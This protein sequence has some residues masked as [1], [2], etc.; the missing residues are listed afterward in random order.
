MAAMLDAPWA[1]AIFAPPT[2]T[3]IATI[4]AAIVAQL[5][6]Q[7]SSIEIAHYPAEP[8]RQRGEY[9]KPDG[10]RHH[11]QLADLAGAPRRG[12]GRMGR[13]LRLRLR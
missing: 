2:P 1:G 7:I 12:A 5:R 4:E 13:A 3:D 8:E 6:S 11:R 10:R 9:D